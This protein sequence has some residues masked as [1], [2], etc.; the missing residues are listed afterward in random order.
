MFIRKIQ[1]RI[2]NRFVKKTARRLKAVYFIA[3]GCLGGF[4]FWAGRKIGLIAPIRDYS[5]DEIKKILVIRMDRIGDVVLSLPTVRALRQNFPRA[6][7]GF[8]TTE[9]TKD[10]V[11]E[12]KDINE[13]IIYC[14][15]FTW[16]GRRRFIKKLRGYGFDLAVVLSPYFES[17]L[18]GYLSA[19]PFRI[20]YPFNGAGFLLTQKAD[21][22]SHYKHEI[23]ACLDVVRMVGVDT[24]EKNPELQLNPGAEKYAA[25]FLNKHNILPADLI[26]SIHP[27]GYEEHTRWMPERYA[28]VAD[29]LVDKYQAKVILLG[30]KADRDIVNNIMKAMSQKAV[31]ADLGNSLP[32]LAAL[33]KHSSIFL[34][35]NSGPMHIAA[36]VGVPVVAIFGA[37]NLLDHENR[38]APQGEKHIIVRKKMDCVDCHPGH[39]RQFD[40]LRMVGVEDVLA[41]V[42]RQIKLIRN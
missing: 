15:N 33:I 39:C 37:I 5:P 6:F 27:G 11:R 34:G 9:Y 35:N 26:I 13:V 19:A 32:E 22:N 12:N 25:D 8:L 18:L 23:E 1:R 17:A 10:L 42:S 29:I 30:A 38:W 7:I 24:P 21:I 14:R 41:A 40:C 20:G 4:I 28:Q 36:A 16:R 31:I 2:K 3:I